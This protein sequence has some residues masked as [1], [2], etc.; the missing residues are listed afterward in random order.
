MPDGVA[1]RGKGRGDNRRKPRAAGVLT[2]LDYA[3]RSTLVV[4][5]AYNAARSLGRVLEQ[6][7]EVSPHLAVLVVDDGSTDRTEAV[8]EIGKAAVVRHE[9]N[10]GKGEALRTGFT[11]FLK[12]G[13]K[14]VITLDADGQHSPAEIPKLMETWLKERADIVIGTRKREVGTMPLVRIFTNTVSSWLVSL[15]A[16]QRIPDSQSGY[17]LIARSVIENIETRSCG[18]GAESEI[19]IK[20]AI[21]GYSIASAP[22]A[23]VYGDE[24]SYIHPLKQ[25]ALFIGLIFKSLFWR[26]QRIG[27]G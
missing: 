27:K 14:A 25:P 13:Y 22:I 1:M 21:A 4:I 20:A 24:T 9:H 18:Y 17:R 19:L 3:Y 6:I 12:R 23:T 16:G 15:S 8:A 2:M 26:W 11:E 7:R 5:P 10:M